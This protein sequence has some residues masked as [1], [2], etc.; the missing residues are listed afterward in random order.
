MHTA[1]ACPTS[2]SCR[3]LAVSHPLPQVAQIVRWAVLS[4]F[5]SPLPLQVFRCVVAALLFTAKAKRSNC[6]P[7]LGQAASVLRRLT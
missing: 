7:E 5:A 2:Q 1:A 3:V 4:R 6:V